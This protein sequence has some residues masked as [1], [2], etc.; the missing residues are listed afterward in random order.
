MKRN[1]AMIVLLVLIIL[2]IAFSIFTYINLKTLSSNLEEGNIETEVTT[3][4]NADI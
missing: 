1:T 4:E 3:I 2:F